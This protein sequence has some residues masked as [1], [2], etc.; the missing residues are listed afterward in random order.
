VPGVGFQLSTGLTALDGVSGH[1]AAASLD[2]IHISAPGEIIGGV[3][4]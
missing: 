2:K 3:I 4:F 1:P